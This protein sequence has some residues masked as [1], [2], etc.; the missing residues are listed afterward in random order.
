MAEAGPQPQGQTATS[1]DPAYRW[2]VIVSTSIAN[3]LEWF[4][5]IVYGFFA[6]VMAKLFFPAASGV[7]ALLA[8]FATFAIPFVVR[9][10]GAVILGAYAD[11]HGRKKTLLLTIGL[12]TLGTA[13]MAAVPTYSA[14]GAW[15]G[16]IVIAAR[17]LQAFSVSGEYGAAVAFLVEQDES[18]RG[19]LASWHY[20]SQSMVAV[21]A[22]GFATVLN[23]TLTA[24]QI[25]S[26]GWRIPF[27]FGLLIAP[28]GLYVRSQLRETESFLAARPSKTP[29][30]EV[31]TDHRSAVALAIGVI[32][33]S[34]VTVYL[35]LFMPTFAIRQ[36]GLPPSVAFLGSMLAGTIHVVLILIVGFFSDRYDRI[37]LSCVASLAVL[38]LAYPLFAFLVSAPSVPALLAVQGVLA[39]FNALNLGCLGAL[40]AGLFPTQLRTS[41]LSIANAFTQMLIGG[42][43]PFISLWLI[44]ATGRPAAPAFYLMFGATLSVVALVVLLRK[45]RL[46]DGRA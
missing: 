2:K 1:P 6:V 13:I 30:R 33:V 36:L 39:V 19:F 7:T 20:A 8:T 12:M 15:A 38:I 44:E 5:F 17:M 22:T 43:T 3:A 24:E 37:T 14:I 16:V 41:G 42:T 32:A 31:I 46:A 4:D 45:R 9:P 29:V 18:R 27:L 25:E 10:I 23:T 26:W 40:V 11:R 28:V 34:A 21:L 35:V